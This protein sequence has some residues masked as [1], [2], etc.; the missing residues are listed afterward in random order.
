MSELTGDVR[1][2]LY[3]SYVHNYLLTYG[4]VFHGND[5]PDDRRLVNNNLRQNSYVGLNP[6]SHFMAYL[7]MDSHLRVLDLSSF[8]RNSKSCVTKRESSQIS[9]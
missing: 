5:F 4:N 8:D 1:R 2:L 7:S 6:E 9:D 3:F